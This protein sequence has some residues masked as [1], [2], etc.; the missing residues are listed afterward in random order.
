[1]LFSTT[2][3]ICFAISWWSVLLAEESEK[4]MDLSQ[5]TAKLYHIMLY[6]RVPIVMGGIRTHNFSD[7]RN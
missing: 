7:D 3:N 1:M 2:F 4:I 5:L 6:H